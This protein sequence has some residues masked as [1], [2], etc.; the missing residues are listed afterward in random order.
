M[1]GVHNRQG[2]LNQSDDGDG[3]I[4]VSFGLA[5]SAIGFDDD[6]REAIKSMT[7]VE[8]FW[9]EDRGRKLATVP[10]EHADD[11]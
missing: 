7:D 5:N 2:R 6:I 9:G 10:C 4:G 11:E 3:I 8:I 1:T